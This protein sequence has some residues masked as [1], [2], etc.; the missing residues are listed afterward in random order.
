MLAAG[1]LGHLFGVEHLPGF[2]QMRQM[3]GIALVMQM[4]MLA[5]GT[6]NLA[7]RVEKISIDAIVIDRVFGK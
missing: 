2:T 4:R 5:G 1:D 6:I 3:F 7:C